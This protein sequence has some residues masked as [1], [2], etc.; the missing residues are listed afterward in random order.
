MGD[1][2]NRGTKER[3]MWYCRY[4]DVDGKR[5]HRPTHQ[6]T[7]ALAMRYVAEVEARV[8]RGLVG[9]PEPA[10][11]ERQGK[12]M[13]LIAL[14]ER[15]LREANPPTKNPERY[16]A[17]LRYTLA[18]HVLPDL[19]AVPIASLKPGQVEALRD[20]KL[21]DGYK[22]A[23]VN[24]MLKAVSVLFIWARK[25]GLYEGM[26]PTSGLRKTPPAGLVDYLSSDEVA[27]L[28]AHTRERA[29]DVFPMIAAAIYTGMRKGELFGLRWIDV[30]FDRGVIHVAHSYGKAPKSGKWRPVPLHPALAP[31]LREW[32]RRC[33]PGPLVFPI[34]SER[35]A[36]PRMGTA[37]DM[38][39][40]EELLQAAGCHVPVRP[41]H[42]MRHTFASHYAM[43]GG[44]LL[45]LQKILG[46]SKFEMTQI[47]SHLAPDYMA[48]E[49]ARLSF[50]APASAPPRPV[51][52][53]RRV[54]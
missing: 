8:A 4:I 11:P 1:V 30:L 41:W 53:H 20:R 18:K 28:L 43:A 22:L 23:T 25:Q 45:A 2:H 21:A 3:P 48:S 51:P 19:G 16:R 14:A 38:L 34:V 27:K 6:P 17:W 54:A 36:S 29:P 24:S 5:K 10:A 47:Y 40:L 39:G 26:N 42:A 44:N 52:L 33:P 46:H 49:I 15:F 31:I 13:T 37:D 12:A 32:Q 50:G 7:K 35:G 9:I